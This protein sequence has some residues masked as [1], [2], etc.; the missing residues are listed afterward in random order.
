MWK[1]E[2]PGSSPADSTPATAPV[3]SVPVV[4]S[5]GSE[6]P[7]PQAASG[8]VAAIGKGLVIRG[9]ISGTDSLFIEGRVEGSIHVGENRV[10]VGRSGQASANITAREVVVLGKVR[11]NIIATDRVEIRAE[12]VVAGDLTAPRISIEDGALFKGTVDIRKVDPK[13]L[14]QTPLYASPSEP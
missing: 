8:E 7:P 11:G 1:S 3:H 14:A 13:A 6:V 5:A 10:T 12:G 4:F 9:E 2:L